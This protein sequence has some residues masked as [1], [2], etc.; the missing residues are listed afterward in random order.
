MPSS[1]IFL[2]NPNITLLVNAGYR[3]KLHMISYSLSLYI[4]IYNI[5]IYTYIYVPYPVCIKKININ[6]LFGYTGYTALSQ[7]VDQTKRRPGGLQGIDD[8]VT[9]LLS[10]DLQL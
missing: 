8:L 10:E 4:R 6:W 1:L 3:Y 7:V 5:Y 2:T 9:D